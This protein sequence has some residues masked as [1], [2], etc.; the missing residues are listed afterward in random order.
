MVNISEKFRKISGNCC[1]PKQWVALGLDLN[2]VAYKKY[3]ITK[4]AE[5][6][7]AFPR[8]L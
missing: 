8:L 2:L 7:I 1:Q 5:T 3:Q 4:N 6:E